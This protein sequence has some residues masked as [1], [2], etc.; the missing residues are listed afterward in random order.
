[1]MGA[2]DV[3]GLVADVMG[4]WSFL[5]D[6]LAPG[7]SDDSVYRI[8]VGVDGTEHNGEELSA[9]PGV[10]DAVKVYNTNHDLMGTGPGGMIGFNGHGFGDV[11]ASQLGSQ[12]SIFTEFFA[13]DDAICM[14]AIGATMPGGT[15]WGWVGDW[16]KLCN[17]DWFYS[18]YHI[19]N[20]KNDDSATALCT[21]IDKDHTNDIKVGVRGIEWSAF[22]GE[23][24]KAPTEEDAKKKCGN[25]LTAWR[26]EGEQQM[27]PLAAV[28]MASSSSGPRPSRR[29]D[30]S[31][32][33]SKL[34]G[35]N[36]TE[37]CASDTALGPDFVSEDEGVYCNMETHE[38][39]PRCSKDPHAPDCFDWA[40]PEGPAMVRRKGK[41]SLRKPSKIVHWG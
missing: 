15:N 29:F 2:A 6:N 35:Q 39:A 34:R 23:P 31:L 13:G 17:L 10:I 14:A 3:I 26:N 7:E 1:M 32:V 16:G 11:T 40:H 41:R 9:A 8:F 38:T 5:G 36:A 18:G 27:L 33:F 30:D 20:D 25:G 21:W 24:Q 12:Q 19:K 37:L 22:S 28:N 4:I